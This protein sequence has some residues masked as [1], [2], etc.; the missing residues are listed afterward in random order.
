MRL[1]NR[2]SFHGRCDLLPWFVAANL[3]IPDLAAA[4][5]IQWTRMAGQWPVEASP[6]VIASTNS[7]TDQI[8]IL[9]R[10]GQLL[11]WSAD[12]AALGPGQDGLVVLLGEMRLQ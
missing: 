5:Q 12:G 6:L 3:A 1:E 10:G 9:N 11:L 7:A 4:M 2:P 8:L